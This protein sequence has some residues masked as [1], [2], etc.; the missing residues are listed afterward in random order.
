MKSKGIIMY[1]LVLAAILF[2]L[3]ACAQQKDPAGENTGTIHTSYRI[4]FS[5]VERFDSA[6]VVVQANG[7]TLFA[8]TYVPA[9]LEKGKLQFSF[10]ATEF[11]AL[12]I[13]CFVYQD[14]ALIARSREILTAGDVPQQPALNLAPL[15]QADADSLASQGKEKT[16]G[17]VAIDRENGVV[18][19]QWDYNGDGAWDDSL[20][21]SLGFS[22]AYADTGRYTAIFQVTDD[23]GLQGRDTLVVVV[24]NHAPI[25][26]SLWFR[27]TLQEDSIVEVYSRYSDFEED[28]EGATTQQWLRDGNMIPGATEVEYA[29]VYA[30]SGAKISCV[31]RPVAKTGTKIGEPDTLLLGVVQGFRAPVAH[32]V[33]ISGT[34]RVDSILEA[35]YT[36][37][38]AD[39]NP[40]GASLYRWYRNDERIEGA[41]QK[42]WKLTVEDQDARIA[43]EVIP[44][45][46][47]GRNSQG[48]AARS[49]PSDNVVNPTAPYVINVS[50]G[51]TL[52]RDST[53]HAVYT[54]HDRDGDLEAGTTFQ[55]YREQTAIPGATAKTYKISLDDLG[56][57]LRVRIIPAAASGEFR[58]SGVAVMSPP[59]GPVQGYTP[60]VA[61]NV[62]ISG[63]F[64]QNGTLTVSY[65]YSDAEDDQEGV[66]V[67]TWYRDG[68]LS[69][70]G[71]SKTYAITKADSGKVISVTITPVA[72]VGGTL[73]GDPVEN[74]VPSPKVTGFHYPVAHGVYVSGLSK[75]GQ[76]IQAH[77]SY[78]DGDGD[79]EGATQIRWCRFNPDDGACDSVGTGSSYLLASI[80]MTAKHPI[81]LEIRPVASSGENL[82]GD[83]VR[84]TFWIAGSGS[85]GYGGEDYPIV[86]A[87]KQDWFTTN[88]RYAVNGVG[89]V[90]VTAGY[91]EADLGRLYSWNEAYP[92]V[93]GQ[94]CP[95]G[96]HMP[97]LEE[98]KE[99]LTL[100]GVLV[101]NSYGDPNV[102][103]S[104]HTSY[105]NSVG[106]D[107]YGLMFHGAG[108]MASGAHY[109]LKTSARIWTSEVDINTPGSSFAVALTTTA[110]QMVSQNQADNKAGVRCIR[111]P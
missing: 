22:H 30:D 103:R 56:A 52:Y 95:E 71:A 76:S 43:F 24:R 32:S 72:N 109:G 37:S 7:D 28:A 51:G 15:A 88:V 42:T 44:V 61:D 6:R 104:S 111:T 9:D 11:E 20:A 50:V 21:T 98:F 2:G 101:G 67:V 26:D 46:L 89:S 93:T 36:Y 48:K 5:H 85:I 102:L 68:I 13:E 18:A 17:G 23:M 12:K 77:Y 84:D 45:S 80:E 78:S 39:G 19:Y 60:P 53:V 64:G 31:V 57:Q 38:D 107:Q 41:D 25:I 14:G 100:V 106:T 81:V 33:K 27:G 90:P 62:A 92:G 86:T 79:S 55:W 54:Y 4:G 1:K 58:N 73:L 110:S 70:Q 82:V 16:F 47:S 97:T 65:H 3:F 8:Q 29:V 63:D 99:L 105:W 49:E 87:G 40:E 96:W 35:A 94:I 108:Y 83:P 59:A 91:S 34:P 10:D 66:S 69:Q 75:L 74:T